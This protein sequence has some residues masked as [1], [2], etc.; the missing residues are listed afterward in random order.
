M[1]NKLGDLVRSMRGDKSL[2]DFAKQCDGLSHTHVDSIEKGFDPRT[3]KPVNISF[4]VLAKLARGTGVDINILSA[5]AAEDMGIV[6]GTQ[7]RSPVTS[8]LRDDFFRL[9][10]DAQDK[11]YSPED[12][13]M[14]LDF[15]ERAR[16]R[17]E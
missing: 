5:L 10:K 7:P 9:M 17:N 3:G 1:P 15:I 12:M 8:G 6:S 2:R 11:G 4:D 13:K 16:K 14:A